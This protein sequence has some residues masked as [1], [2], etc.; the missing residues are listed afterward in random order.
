MSDRGCRRISDTCRLIAMLT[1][2]QMPGPLQSRFAYRANIPYIHG[3]GNHGCC[4]DRWRRQPAASIAWFTALPAQPGLSPV[5]NIR[6]VSAALLGTGN[7][8]CDASHASWV[9]RALER[10]RNGAN[11]DA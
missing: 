6:E 11:E 1:R 8:S 9:P 3:T 7:T 5:W 4:N 2:R 10:D